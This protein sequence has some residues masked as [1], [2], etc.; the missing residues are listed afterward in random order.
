MCERCQRSFTSWSFQT[1]W[2]SRAAAQGLWGCPQVRAGLSSSGNAQVRNG[3]FLVNNFTIDKQPYIQIPFCVSLNFAETMSSI[4]VYFKWIFF[5]SFTWKR[6]RHTSDTAGEM[7]SGC[8][9]CPWSLSTL[10]NGKFPSVSC[11]T[12]SLCFFF[13]LLSSFENGCVPSVKDQVIEQQII[14]SQNYRRDFTCIQVIV[15][16]VLLL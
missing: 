15:L 16:L 3:H 12:C 9:L 10:Q 4:L 8:M 5:C 6:A 11:G 7:K 14:S 2:G 13:I 1:C